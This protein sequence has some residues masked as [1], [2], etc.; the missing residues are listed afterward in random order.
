M[1]QFSRELFDS[2][3]SDHP[4]CWR[5]FPTVVAVIPVVVVGVSPISL[6][7]TVS[8]YSLDSSLFIRG[9]VHLVHSPTSESVREG[10]FP[11]PQENWLVRLT[12]D[13]ASCIHPAFPYL[14]LAQPWVAG[15]QGGCSRHRPRTAGQADI[16]AVRGTCL[17]RRRRRATGR[18]EE[19][20]DYHHLAPTNRHLTSPMVNINFATTQQVWNC[21]IQ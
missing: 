13:G 2:G 1:T 15:R 7:C 21:L 20:R 5:V 6:Y 19:V 3:I 11:G 4:D 8:F 14:E 17:H 18:T 10:M 16:P 12:E 9:F